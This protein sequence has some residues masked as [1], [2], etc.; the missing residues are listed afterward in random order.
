[1]LFKRDESFRFTFESPVEA[2]F[3]IIRSN[4]LN[5][6]LKEGSALIIDLSPNGLR[7]SS[8]LDLAINEKNNV[9]MI[10][11]V[12]NTQPLTIMAEPIWKKRTSATSFSYGLV[13]VNDEETKDM[14]I[15]ELK[16]FTK[17]NST[18]HI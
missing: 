3:K 6:P 2:T 14:I 12:L 5:A 18:H 17:K 8:P 9:L 7:L 15:T 1:M 16:E 4:Q 10:S 11:F 13:G